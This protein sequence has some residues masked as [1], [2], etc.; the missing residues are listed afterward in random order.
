MTALDMRSSL[1]IVPVRFLLEA[2]RAGCAIAHPALKPLWIQ[3]ERG[4]STWL[5]AVDA[6]IDLL[7]KQVSNTLNRVVFDAEVSD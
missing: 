5:H 1:A 2:Q 6:I 4:K 3:R 7:D